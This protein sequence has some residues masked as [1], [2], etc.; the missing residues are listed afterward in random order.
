M[1][2]YEV[3]GMSCAAC[4]ARVEK[5][6]AKIDGVDSV[7]VN[8][9][10]N[11]M[12]VE[13]RASEKEIIEAVTNAGYGAKKIGGTS[14]KY[15]G[16]E[17]ATANKESK[18][19][20]MEKENESEFL[21]KETPK[22]IRRLGFSIIFLIPLMYI[23]M[24]HMMFDW[25]LPSFFEGDS[26]G[27]VIVEMLLSLIVMIINQKFFVSGTRSLLHGGPNMD[28]LVAMG[29]GVSFAYSFV[30]LLLMSK[31]QSIQ[32]DMM[33]EEYM[34]DLYFESAAM[35]VTLITVGKTLESYSKEKLQMN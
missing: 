3:T 2:R 8:L 20:E 12:Q 32:N 29:A 4:Q 22:M 24:G 31:A 21:D 33:V 6:V 1:D 28:T 19:R 7:A 35:I 18:K 5:A 13:G 34:H 11:S 15:N 10:T 30:I 16:M 9:L 14:K 23:S 26:V 25:P 17:D 27:V